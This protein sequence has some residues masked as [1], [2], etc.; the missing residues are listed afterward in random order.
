MPRSRFLALSVLS[1]SG[2]DPA[3][4]KCSAQVASSDR[5]AQHNRAMRQLVEFEERGILPGHQNQKKRA[6]SFRFVP[7]ATT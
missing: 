4:V 1:D 5:F 3:P 6:L 7:S 2:S